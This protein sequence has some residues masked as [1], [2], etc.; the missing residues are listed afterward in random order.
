MV[1]ATI[2]DGLSNRAEAVFFNRAAYHKTALKKDGYY[3]FTGKPTKTKYGLQLAHPNYRLATKDEIGSISDS[4][5]PDEKGDSES[6]D[7]LMP[8]YHLK[9]SMTKAGLTNLY[10]QKLIKAVIDSLI[11]DIKDDFP[12]GLL[13]IRDLSHLSYS[14]RNMHFPDD[15]DSLERSVKRFKYQE[16]FDFLLV[17]KHNSISKISTQAPVVEPASATARKV[18]DA[19]PFELT[20]DQKKVLREIGAD[21]KK[22]KPMNR[23]LQGDVGAGKTLVALLTMLM[24]TDS[25]YQSILLAP[26]E[27]LAEQHYKSFLGYLRDTDIGVEL[28]TGGIKAKNKRKSH[29]AVA[30][31]QADIIIGTHALFQE[32]VKYSRLAYI[33]IDEQHRFGV[34]QRATL[35]SMAKESLQKNSLSGEKEFEPH[36]LLMSAT[37]IPRTIS[38]SAYGDLDLSF[39]KTKPSNRKP[40]ITQVVSEGSRA[41]VYQF[42][43][44]E[45]RNGHKIFMLYPLV[46]DSDKLDLVSVEKAF[47]DVSSV[48]GSDK[49]KVLHGRMSSEEKD[50]IM[51]AFKKGEFDVL[52][53]TTV[54]EVGIDITE[55]TV[56]IINH[57]ERFG[58]SQLHQLRGRVGR[59]DLQ[60]YCYLITHE[61]NISTDKNSSLFTNNENIEE[62]TA[63]QRLRVMEESNDGFY[64]SEKDLELRGPGDILGVRQSGMP[65]FKF[66]DLKSDLEIIQNA[67]NDVAEIYNNAK[68]YS[69]YQPYIEKITSIS[70]NS[71][72]DIA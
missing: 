39:I 68:S 54:I 24:A 14:I 11:A 23:L 72:I 34:E 19:L 43:K 37:P 40:I 66:I 51:K 35:K 61:K 58:L 48:F 67:R 30:S 22:G 59:S 60:S 27:I 56:M 31:G 5:E 26:T 16:I 47:E 55:A 21:L 57:A 69:E 9:E 28:L 17:L 64:I 53:S 38:L 13:A 25:G 45:I 3:T 32:K 1:A 15:S 33:V 41:E 49:T 29:S 71:K 44:N 10:L 36:T 7:K 62:P 63:K 18:Y 46:E 4:A 20:S 50:T 8:R 2:K 65:N 42:C 12:A 52:I 6:S 70:G